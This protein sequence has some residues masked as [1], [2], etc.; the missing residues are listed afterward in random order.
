MGGAQECTDESK[1]IMFDLLNL[2]TTR[3]P[4]MWAVVGVVH[5]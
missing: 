5:K 4:S 1:R 2:H 3:T